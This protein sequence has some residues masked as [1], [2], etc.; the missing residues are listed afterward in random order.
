MADY[1]EEVLN[2]KHLEAS[3]TAKQDVHLDFYGP[4]AVESRNSYL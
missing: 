3:I 4:G 1:E 2:E